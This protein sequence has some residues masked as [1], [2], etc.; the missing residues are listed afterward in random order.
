[1]KK[2]D[3]NVCGRVAERG[4][5]LVEATVTF[6]LLF[7]LLAAIIQF[8]YAYA[9]LITLQNASVIAARTAILSSGKSTTQVCDAARVA[10]SS[11]VDPAQLVCATTPAILPASPDTAITV[12]LTYSIP[13]LLDNGLIQLEPNWTLQARAVMQ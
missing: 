7:A 5:V 12:Q 1:M 10:V 6:P 4:S 13:L 9:V 2:L 8:G 11:I 3:L